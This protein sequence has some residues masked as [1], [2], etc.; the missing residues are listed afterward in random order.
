MENLVRFFPRQTAEGLY[1][2]LEIED[3]EV[4]GSEDKP[5]LVWSKGNS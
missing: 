1:P 4:T 5:S 2:E 3:Y